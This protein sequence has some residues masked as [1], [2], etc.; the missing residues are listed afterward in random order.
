MRTRCLENS[1]FAVTANRFG[2]DIRPRGTLTF[3]GQSQLVGPEGELLYQA[4]PHDEELFIAEVDL[5]KARN[6]SMT[7]RNNLLGDRRP[8]YYTA[9][10]ED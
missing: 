10:I 7:E 5:S 8:E 6:K 9:L 1:V 3:T 4:K 2:S